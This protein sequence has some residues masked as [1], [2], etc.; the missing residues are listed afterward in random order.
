MYT[1]LPENFGSNILF[2]RA[3]RGIGVSSLNLRLQQSLLLLCSAHLYFFGLVS[4][5]EAIVYRHYVRS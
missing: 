3:M 4:L 5:V 2:T 1:L